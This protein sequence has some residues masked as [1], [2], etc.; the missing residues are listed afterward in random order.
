VLTGFTVLCANQDKGGVA[1]KNCKVACIGCMKCQ[2]VCPAG[3]ITVENNLA[4][5]DHEKCENCG[6]CAEVCP[7]STIHDAMH[8]RFPMD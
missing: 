3:A 8:E 6:K 5:I 1:R 4:R 7:Q 2:K